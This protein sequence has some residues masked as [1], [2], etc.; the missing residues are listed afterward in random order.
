MWIYLARITNKKK[1]NIN[2]GKGHTCL[3]NYV[4]HNS[5]LHSPPDILLEN[6]IKK[7]NTRTKNRNQYHP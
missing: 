7:N 4:P 3:E 2:K 6:T 1:Q 5:S